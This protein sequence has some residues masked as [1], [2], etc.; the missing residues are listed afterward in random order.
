MHIIPASADV[1][2]FVCTV[3]P[4]QKIS[5]K[6]WLVAV[7]GPDNWGWSSSLT[8]NDTGE[9]ACE[10]FYVD[11]AVAISGGEEAKRPEAVILT[12]PREPGP[13]PTPQRTRQEKTITLTKTKTFPIP[14]GNITVS[15]GDAVR[16]TAENGSK[17][18]A[19]YRGID[20][21]VERKE[22]E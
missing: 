22:L 20:F 13:S 8:R 7:S 1:Q 18:K 12:A 6:G 2:K 17:V 11:R 21:W 15:A 3:Q 14:Y 10:V 5:L 19:A 16:I 4:G 9:G